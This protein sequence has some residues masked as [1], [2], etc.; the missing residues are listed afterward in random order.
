MPYLNSP[1]PNPEPI[2][3][4]ILTSALRLFVEHGYHC[5]SIHE[6]QKL[7]GVSIGSI[8][9]YFD[10]KPGIAG[11]LYN[12]ILKEI[13]DLFDKIITDNSAPKAQCNVII[14]KLFTHTE[15]HPDIIAY[16]FHTKHSEFL[17]D[18]LPICESTPFLKM[19]AIIAE[20][21]KTGD[22]K[23]ADP[24][25]ATACIF[26]SMAR[27]IQLRLDRRITRPLPELTQ[28]TIHSIWN[29]LESPT[30]VSN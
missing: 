29:G 7:S 11:A 1:E 23:Q 9:K 13:E 24:W 30:P 22:I 12:R 5:V 14:E 17:P 20:G 19:Q 2:D 4:K 26:G 28:K 18:M 8:Y 16:I 10:G 15:T 3:C 6:I 21:I 27:M 25:V